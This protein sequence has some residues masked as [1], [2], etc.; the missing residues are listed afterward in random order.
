MPADTA[1]V[2]LPVDRVEGKVYRPRV[3]KGAGSLIAP[4]VALVLGCS[5]FGGGSGPSRC[6]IDVVGIEEWSVHP[7]QVDVSYQVAGEAGSAALTW[8]AAKIGEKRYLTGGGVDVGPGPFKAIITLKTTG[9]PREYIALLEVNGR[10]CQ[11]KAKM[12]GD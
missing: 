10:R 11:A 5:S 12:A 6:K 9:L 2:P 3:I 1:L 4:A 7:G 8:L